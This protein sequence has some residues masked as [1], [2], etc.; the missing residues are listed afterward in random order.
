MQTILY[1]QKHHIEYLFPII[2]ARMK[3]LKNRLIKKHQ[4]EWYDLE[5]YQIHQKALEKCDEYN[6]LNQVAHQ[7]YS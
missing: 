5:D 1:L 6:R 2:E 7:I 4:N 3:V